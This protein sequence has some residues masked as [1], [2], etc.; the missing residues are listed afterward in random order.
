MQPYGT[1]PAGQVPADRQFLAS[2]GVRELNEGEVEALEA[3]RAHVPEEHKDKVPEADTLAV[4]EVPT[5]LV[6][7]GQAHGGIVLLQLQ[8]A[9]P[10]DIIEGL[11]EGRLRLMQG[12]PEAFQPL[13][14]ALADN[15]V[16][17]LVVK[18]EGLAE[19]ARGALEADAGGAEGAEGSKQ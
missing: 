5:Q 8:A 9:L 12:R 15:P 10:P 2:A 13:L 16:L 17:R 1:T 6:G 19:K 3:A 11:T 4:L 14:Q 18:R 7:A